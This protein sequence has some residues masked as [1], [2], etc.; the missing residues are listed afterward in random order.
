MENEIIELLPHQQHEISL[1]IRELADR[2]REKE[3]LEESPNGIAMFL[4]IAKV[5]ELVSEFVFREF[6]L[7]QPMRSPT[8]SLELKNVFDIFTEEVKKEITAATSDEEVAE[9]MTKLILKI[10][11]NDATTQ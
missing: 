4:S 10:R 6:L 7:H 11:N 9:R 3:R 1:F 8:G 5:V 2:L